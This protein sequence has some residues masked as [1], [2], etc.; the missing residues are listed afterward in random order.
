MRNSNRALFILITFLSAIFGISQISAAEDVLLG[1]P[2]TA[3]E[4][5]QW[6]WAGSS[7]AVLD[8]YG[9]SVK[10]CDIANW[11][12]G[13]NDC[14]SSAAF[15]W[16]SECN[17]P[18]NMFPTSDFHGS[19]QDILD[20][21]GV[22]STLLYTSLP[23][24]DFIAQ[25]DSGRPFVMRFGWT[26]G[27]G[28]FLDG[29]GYHESGMYMDYMDPWP[30]NG[31]TRSLYSWVVSADDHD[32]THTLQITSQVTVAQA[33]T[34]SLKG[35]GAGSVSWSKVKCST[36]TCTYTYQPGTSLTLTAKAAGGSVLTGWTGCTSSSGK[37]C[38]VTMSDDVTVSATFIMPPH[39]SVSPASLNF[40]TVKTDGSYEKTIS[41]N[42]TGVTDLVIGYN[43]TG[44]NSSEFSASGCTDPV[45]TGKSCTLTVDMSPELPYGSKSA[46]LHISSN[47]PRKPSL[48]VRLSA[49]AK[50]PRISVSPKSLSFGKVAIGVDPVPS[51]TVTIKNT[52]I[53]DLTIS[54][55]DPADTSFTATA[56]PGCAGPL[57][58]PGTPCTITVT[59]DP[60]DTTFRKD[61]ISITS[62]AG[63]TQVKVKLSGQGK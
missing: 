6:C 34:V 16:S 10:Q 45:T 5:S 60:T 32:W 33:L 50:S 44:T 28:H 53:S 2:E 25:I 4:H 42:N 51:K 35:N 43:I 14:C 3:Q 38:L 40:G 21:W 1:V 24:P 17:Q 58:N 55:S 11:A 29:Y 59:F 37:T 52:G 13:K 49:N 63:A 22:A 18:N 57:Q 54:I 15:K 26:G 7:K 36:G 39:M 9:S 23:Q 27:G 47:D 12:W 48:T 41:V 19:L 56:G 62:N 61:E 31:Y 8:Y 46:Q 20:H 30:G